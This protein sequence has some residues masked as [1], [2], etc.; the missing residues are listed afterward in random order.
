MSSRTIGRL[1]ARVLRNLD[2]DTVPAVVAAEVRELTSAVAARRER[3]GDV[4]VDLY[5]ARDGGGLSS[6]PGPLLTRVVFVC[7]RIF[8]MQG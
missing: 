1:I 5:T 6:P 4:A 7:I 3:E 8:G 2:D